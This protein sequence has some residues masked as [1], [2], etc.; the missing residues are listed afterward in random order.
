MV[1]TGLNKEFPR[2]T[3]GEVSAFLCIFLHEHGVNPVKVL[4]KVDLRH[5]TQADWQ[6]VDTVHALYMATQFFMSQTLHS[7]NEAASAYDASDEQ[8]SLVDSDSDD[9]ES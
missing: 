3:P 8:P 4:K 2:P 5:A 9:S 1:R 7:D 6:D